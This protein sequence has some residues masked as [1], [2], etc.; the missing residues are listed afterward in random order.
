MKQLFGIVVAIA[1]CSGLEAANLTIAKNMRIDTGGQSEPS[2]V[3]SGKGGKKQ[4][5]SSTD[6]F[7]RSLDRFVT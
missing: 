2:A 1:F 4:P 7:T 6:G 3:R 5:L